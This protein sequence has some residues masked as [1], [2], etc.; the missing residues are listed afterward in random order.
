MIFEANGVKTGG[1]ENWIPVCLPGFN[2]AGYLYMYVSFMDLRSG[3]DRGADMDTNKDDSVA[4]ILISADKES[5]YMLRQMRNSV[6]E[7]SDLQ[8]CMLPGNRVTDKQNSKWGKM[9]V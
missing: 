6:V 3:V 1:G 7:A 5:F 9:A 4:I 8:M 2:S